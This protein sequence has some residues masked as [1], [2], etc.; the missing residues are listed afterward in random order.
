MRTSKTKKPVTPLEPK[1]KPQTPKNKRLIAAFHEESLAL[2]KR[3]NHVLVVLSGASMGDV[4]EMIRMVSKD[5]ESNLAKRTA[6]SSRPSPQGGKLDSHAGLEI[7]SKGKGSGDAFYIFAV[8]SRSKNGGTASSRELVL[9][10]QKYSIRRPRHA[11]QVHFALSSDSMEDIADLLCLQLAPIAEG[12][13]GSD[14]VGTMRT[15]FTGIGD[16]KVVG[17]TLYIFAEAR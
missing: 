13:D 2:P 16:S 1:A 15:S 4:S 3:K 8:P 17:E 9:N 14:Y 6:A 5:I 7:E 10:F 12:A 11:N